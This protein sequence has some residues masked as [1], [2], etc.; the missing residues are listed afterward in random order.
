MSIQVSVQEAK[1]HAQKQLRLASGTHANPLES[2]RYLIFDT[3]KSQDKA[4]NL[5]AGVKC[6][7]A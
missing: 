2:A 5:L 4:E 7:F 1:T 6:I 3:E